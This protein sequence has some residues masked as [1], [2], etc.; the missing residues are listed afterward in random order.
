[1]TETPSTFRTPR[2]FR[3]DVAPEAD[4][5]IQEEAFPENAEAETATNLSEKTVSHHRLNWG[6]I[7]ASSLGFLLVLAVGL[8]IEALIRDLFA[9]AP[10]LG[11]AGLAASVVALLA[12]MALLVREILGLRREQAITQLRERTL[13]SLATRDE[14]GA[15]QITQELVRLYARH[16]ETARGRALIESHQNDI[17][18]AQDRLAFCERVLLAPLDERAKRLIGSSARQVS[19]VTALSP[20]ALIDIAFVLFAAIQLLRALSSLYGCRP[21]LFGFLRLM[22]AALLHLAVTGGL[23]AGD[24]LIQQFLGQ[25]LAAR[26]SARLGEGVL[27]G[28][29]TARF[30][31]AALAV[32]R[33][34]PF[35]DQ[36]APRWSDLA[37]EI[38][39]LKK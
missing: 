5:Q 6:K 31:A 18:S 12:L 4:W 16:P 36:P 33:P 20:R 24:S 1:M 8:G 37:A 30:G 39:P 11:W 26:V 29:M 19:L 23:A 28:L 14:V 21:G 22:R 27:N 32:C 13:Q 17:L 9:A 7:L 35:I 34:L 2:A 25:G 15:L 3:L 38:L 10:L